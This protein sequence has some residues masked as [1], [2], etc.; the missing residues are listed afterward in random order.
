MNVSVENKNVLDIMYIT[1]GHTVT[2]N[3]RHTKKF[4]LFSGW[5]TK[6]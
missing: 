5:T 3:G 2:L 6:R 1:I 4:V